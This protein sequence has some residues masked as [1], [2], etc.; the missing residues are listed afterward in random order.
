MFKLHDKTRRWLTLSIFLLLGPALLLFVLGKVCSRHS[1]RTVAEWETLLTS[2]LGKTVEIE[3]V[4]FPAPG[5][6]RFSQMRIIDPIN[7]E[8]LALV[9]QWELI[10]I[11]GEM[12]QHIDPAPKDDNSVTGFDD[13]YILQASYKRGLTGSI[14]FA[15]SNVFRAKQPRYW[16]CEIPSLSCADEII[17][18]A[19]DLLF[20]CMARQPEP[21]GAAT[22]ARS[23][24]V[25]PAVLFIGK[26]D[27]VFQS[28][29]A[30]EA[31]AFANPS[32][33]RNVDSETIKNVCFEFRPS[34]DQTDLLAVFLLDEQTTDTE[35]YRFS[36]SRTRQPDVTTRVQLTTGEA[37]IAAQLLAHVEPFF[38]RF[39]TQ[40][41]FR[42]TVIA[43]NRGDKNKQ[44][45][46]SLELKQAS[47]AN[48]SLDTF[49]SRALSFQLTGTADRINLHEATFRSDAVD[50]KATNP[51][52]LRLE[53][54]KGEVIN[55][56]GMG[57]WPGLR[58][59]IQGTNLF[60][61]PQTANPPDTDITFRDGT[62][63]FV[64][65][66]QG[67]RLL[68]EIRQEQNMPLL[69]VDNHCSIHW[70]DPL[71]IIRYN[72][73]LG[74]LARVNSPQIPL[75]TETQYLI[76][77]LPIAID[78]NDPSVNA[79]PVQPYQQQAMQPIMPAMP[80]PSIQQPTP[81]PEA[82]PP[83][84]AV[85]PQESYRSQYDMSS[86]SSDNNIAGMTSQPISPSPLPSLPLL[87]PQLHPEPVSLGE[88]RDDQVFLNQMAHQQSIAPPAT[89]QQSSSFLLS[90][91]AIAI[92]QPSQTQV[93]YAGQPFLANQ[94]PQ[95]QIT[96]S[97]ISTN[98]NIIQ[99]DVTAGHGF[100]NIAPTFENPYDTQ[101]AIGT[102]STPQTLNPR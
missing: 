85:A 91:N 81:Q 75:M 37:G 68:P 32:S 92:P 24:G 5:V 46:R 99:T 10:E 47:F 23:F 8:M 52:A 44:Q 86:I 41:R 69:V 35:P 15:F 26:V 17:P 98:R 78:T 63:A 45:T 25:R 13:S 102:N 55:A 2:S 59:L 64:F 22:D 30:S 100:D 79:I 48:V 21:N 53:Y 65:D 14:G 57:W 43:E 4:A 40:S 80:Q 77:T 29:N 83:L 60:V 49:L 39:G 101:V 74:A 70:P 72:S 31:E 62:F 89:I 94:Q 6:V 58:Q 42:G 19:K 18:H 51:D 36:A 12:P 20:D 28:Q 27:I 67:I 76:S 38:E 66:S 34:A 7:G 54:A 50:H 16:H 90:N 84:V 56:R 93:P 97:E 9:P 1:I 82:V 88:Q 71:H 95:R 87:L 3:S 73:L 61:F 96:I 11:I 33:K